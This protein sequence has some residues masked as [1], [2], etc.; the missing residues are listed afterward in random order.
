MPSNEIRVTRVP[1]PSLEQLEREWLELE[2]T[3]DHS[4]FMSW[5][6]IGSWLARLPADVPRWLLRAE[7]GGRLVGLGVLCSNNSRRH[8]V[9]GSRSLHLHATG[10]SEVDELTVEYNGFLAEAGLEQAVARGCI[11]F[12]DS[13]DDW[14]ELYLD[15]LHQLSLVDVLRQEHAGA[16]R[17]VRRECHYVDLEALRA[18]GRRYADCLPKNI[19]YNLRRSIRDYS[20]RGAIAFDI[21]ATTEEALAFLAGLK[22]LHQRSW[23]ARGQPGAFAN[24]F[25]DEFHRELVRRLFP[26]NLIQLTRLRVGDHAI[27]YFYN[28]VHQGHLYHYQS[29]LD[30][31][32]DKKLSPGTVC[33]AYAVEFNLMAGQKVYDFM[34][35]ELRYKKDHSTNSKEM[36]WLVLQKPRLKFLV[37]DG[38]RALKNRLSARPGRPA[39]SGGAQ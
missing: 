35:G 3:S 8:G 38:L 36:H 12:L 2:D 34:A 10:N 5:H 17:V 28:F 39:A 29:G 19:Q 16:L 27:G 23:Q 30:F 18:T 15:G 13:D 31:D 4:F 37:E 26:G 33:H 32:F 24:R 21:A 7:T 11:R 22:E 20:K 9:F 14:D 6:W 1:L 25:F